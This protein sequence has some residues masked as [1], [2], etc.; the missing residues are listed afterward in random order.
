MTAPPQLQIKVVPPPPKTISAYTPVEDQW[1]DP[2][3]TAMF[4]GVQEKR[5]GSFCGL[6]FLRA[7]L[8]NR[9]LSRVRPSRRLRWN[10]VLPAVGPIS[11]CLT[12]VHAQVFTRPLPPIATRTRLSF[13]RTARCLDT[14]S[15][16]FSNSVLKA[17]RWLFAQLRMRRTLTACGLPLSD[18]NSGPQT[19]TL[20]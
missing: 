19:L 2:A 6:P 9:R 13:C 7:S 11:A 15:I 12:S 1:S 20:T 10:S 3:Y 8:S 5:R 16:E 14:S 18:G 17:S 4:C